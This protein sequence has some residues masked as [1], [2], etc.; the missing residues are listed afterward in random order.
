MEYKIKE[1]KPDYLLFLWSLK[2]DYKKRNNYWKDF[3]KKIDTHFW[4]DFF[5]FTTYMFIETNRDKFDYM[6][7]IWLLEKI[8]KFLIIDIKWNNEIWVYD[9]NFVIKKENIEYDII[10]KWDK[11]ND[12]FIELDLKKLEKYTTE[13]LEK[14]YNW[15][16]EVSWIKAIYYYKP[17]L[18]LKLLIK[19]INKLYLLHWDTTF[20]INTNTEDEKIDFNTCLL[21]L[22]YKWYIINN[23][24]PA[25]ED[26]SEFYIKID[27]SFFNLVIQIEWWNQYIKSLSINN[28]ILYNNSEVSITP[29]EYKIL[30]KFFKSK[31]TELNIFDKN[32]NQT[33]DA[34]KK[35]VTRLN[36]K[37]WIIKVSKVGRKDLWYLEK[38]DK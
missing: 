32:I 36:W 15:L 30:S 16:L 23:E 13:Y 20:P 3:R 22:E 17:D 26:K 8:I 6:F 27:K 4:K 21:F 24:Y 25:F 35:A 10:K 19:E 37:L 7:K 1:Y 38:V 28:V 5:S 9:Y 33:E 31:K 11:I 12:I 2:K 18:Q 14:W 29:W 34:F